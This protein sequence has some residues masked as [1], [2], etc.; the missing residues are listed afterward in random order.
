MEGKDGD[1]LWY[2]RAQQ[3]LEPHY[4]DYVDLITEIK[5]FG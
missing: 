3:E 4:C 2:E 1:I 5:L